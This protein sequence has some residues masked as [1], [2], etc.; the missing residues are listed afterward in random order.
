MTGAAASHAVSGDAAWH[1][2]VTLV[3]AAL[4]VVSWA[5]RHPGRISKLLVTFFQN[6]VAVIRVCMIA[7][8]F[9]CVMM[10]PK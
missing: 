2:I 8:R 6:N 9:S 5:L 1:V 10:K 4:A 3:F 7:L